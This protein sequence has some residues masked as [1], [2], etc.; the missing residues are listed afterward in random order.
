MRK[1]GRTKAKGN[2]KGKCYFDS[3]VRNPE[4][5]TIQ[6]MSANL[7]TR[8]TFIYQWY[9]FRALSWR[10]ARHRYLPAPG[11]ATT[12]SCELRTM[13][14]GA[15]GSPRTPCRLC[16]TAWIK[17]PVPHFRLQKEP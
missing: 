14:S 17:Y 16:K 9:P 6:G 15:L 4:A 7:T 10:S 8:K 11:K 1:R 12:P 5:M 13:D 2:L 3:I